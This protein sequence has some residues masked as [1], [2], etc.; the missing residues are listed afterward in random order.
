MKK[1][2]GIAV[3]CILPVIGSA[4]T[5]ACGSSMGALYTSPV[6]CAESDFGNKIL[7]QRQID[8][9]KK[10]SKIPLVRYN[11]AS[12]LLVEPVPYIE[13]NN[14][15]PAIPPENKTALLGI[16]STVDS[17][18]T[19]PYSAHFAKIKI[20]EVTQSTGGKIVVGCGLVNAKNN[21]GGYIGYTMFSVLYSSSGKQRYAMLA[22]LDGH[23]PFGLGEIQANYNE[24]MF[25]C[26]SAETKGK[27]LQ[28]FGRK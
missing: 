17:I 8:Y 1:I 19:D 25:L 16:I 15:R 20:Y 22:E 9:I 6:R 13:T 11:L 5:D 10:A 28:S 4:S 12:D 24:A 7:T 2:L 27:L 18:L 21:Y 3:G 26:Y 23:S 14:D